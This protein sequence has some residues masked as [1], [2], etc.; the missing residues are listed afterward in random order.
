MPRLDGGRASFCGTDG[1]SPCAPEQGGRACLATLGGAQHCVVGKDAAGQLLDHVE[2]HIM[3]PGQAFKLGVSHA[4]AALN[5]MVCHCSRNRR[6]RTPV[7][8]AVKFIGQRAQAGSILVGAFWNARAFF[9][10]AFGQR[11]RIAASLH[12]IDRVGAATIR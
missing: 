4:P 12:Q 11:A 10:A 9:A 7:V 5:G 1:I 6:Q 8:S 3:L 2:R